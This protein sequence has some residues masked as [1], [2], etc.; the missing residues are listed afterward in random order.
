MPPAAAARV[1]EVLTVCRS[2]VC[3][4]VARGGRAGLVFQFL[5]SLIAVF[6][7]YFGQEWDEVCCIHPWL[8][9]VVCAMRCGVLAARCV[10]VVCV[11]LCVYVRAR[12]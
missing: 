9:W 3:V 4:H 11:C 2:P 6:T 10:V 12:A 1:R 7:G 8:S 5:Q